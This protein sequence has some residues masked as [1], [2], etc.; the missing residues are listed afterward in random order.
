MIDL[1]HGSQP[2]YNEDGLLVLIYN[3]EIYNFP[4]LSHLFYNHQ[5]VICT[6]NK[7][8]KSTHFPFSSTILLTLLF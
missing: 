7:S 8:C 3:G 2:I 1:D 6:S 5:I 4:K